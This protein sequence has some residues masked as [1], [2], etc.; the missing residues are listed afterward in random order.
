M[1]PKAYNSFNKRAESQFQFGGY[2]H[3]LTVPEGAFYDMQDAS[4]DRYPVLTGRKPRGELKNGLFYGVCAMGE[5]L[6]S[7]RKV[8][9]KTKLFINDV[10]VDIEAGA[11][12][13]DLNHDGQVTANDLLL[14]MEIASR[15][16]TAQE[17]CDI[18]YAGDMDAFMYQADIDGDG[19]I[20][21]NDALA[22][23]RDLTA[24]EQGAS[25]KADLN[26]DGQVT[27]EDALLCF[28]ISAGGTK[29]EQEA[30]CAEL[31][32]N[33]RSSLTATEMFGRAHTYTLDP[34][35]PITDTDASYILKHINDTGLYELTDGEKV[36]VKFGTQLIIFPDK[37]VFD[38]VS[39]EYKKLEAA[40]IPGSNVTVAK[41][42]C[43]LDGTAITISSTSET[44]PAS[45]SDG[46]YWV[47]TS[48]GKTLKLWSAQEQKWVSIPTAY[49]KISA[50][51]IGR[52]FRVY[53]AVNIKTGAEKAENGDDVVNGNSYVLW[54][55]GNDYI[56]ITAFEDDIDVTNITL[57][58]VIPDMDHVC[59]H[60]NRLWGCSS[61]KNEIYC[62]VQ[63]DPTNFY[64]YLGVSGDG[65]A[66]SVASAGPFTGCIEYD[67]GVLFFKEDTLH[68]VYGS[69]P[70]NFKVVS[71]ACEGVEKS[72]SAS[73]ANIGGVLYYNSPRGIQAFNGAPRFI[74]APF[75]GER[76]TN[77][78]ACGFERKYYVSMRGNEAGFYIYDTEKRIWLREDGTEA[79]YLTAFDGD[80]LFAEQLSGGMKLVSE[81]G[82]NHF[83][84]NTT[85]EA[86]F[87]WYVE[88]GDLLASP[89]P[90]KHLHGLQLRYSVPI[91]GHI[92]VYVAYDGGD[93]RRVWADEDTVRIV[94]KDV[95]LEAE[96]CD[97]L[98]VKIVCSGDVKLYAM[99]RMFS[100]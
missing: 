82:K 79:R 86:A 1:L 92:K 38:T 69:R 8:S 6:Y 36:L 17:V 70:A 97:Y 58:R 31:I 59:E 19:V 98:R 5:K 12:K 57:K 74:G 73:L 71:A 100:L 27:V 78:F 76:F 3:D 35:D 55:K 20:T 9:Q 13:G 34:N 23:M 63:G 24:A 41:T 68:R 66:A 67:D 60:D 11:N 77:A 95:P 25:A 48:S 39:C 29:S 56:I 7:V 47:D 54:G 93:F 90:D 62:S 72:S 91:G 2:Y 28:E 14:A 96:R 15:R 64:R 99:T 37:V 30:K 49:T 80:V 61:E 84:Q 75:G 40:W 83:F 18:Y 26:G 85:N 32:R 16:K 33:G 94:A 44:P 53:D 4:C 42:P 65:W 51:D 88:T 45:P 46:D 50:T 10:A 81:F 43:T 21:V 87:E 22:I 89:A 52:P